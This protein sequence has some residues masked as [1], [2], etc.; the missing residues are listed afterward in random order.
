MKRIAVSTLLML[1]STSFVFAQNSDSKGKFSGYMFGDYYYNMTRDASI[2]TLKNVANGGAQDLNGIGFRRI[3]FAYSYDISSTFSTLFRLESD[4]T[5]ASNTAGGKLGVMVKDASLTWKNIFSGSDFIFGLQPT[6]AFDISESFWGHRFLEKTIMDLRG[7]VASRD[8]ALA[9][10]GKLD[11]AGTFRY[12]LMFGDGSGNAPEIDNYKRYYLNLQYL[13]AK[14]FTVTLY[15][16]LKA[17]PSI[18]NPASTSSPPATISNNEITYAFFAGYN[19]K[20]LFQLGAEG[21]LHTVENGLVSG[22]NAQNLNAIGLTVYGSYYFTDELS[23]TARFDYYN[24]NTNSSYTGD[25][26]NL[27]ILSVNY[28]PAENVT[29][30]PNVLVETYEKLPNGTT[31]KPSVTPRL[32]FFYKFF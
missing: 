15:T 16:D 28:E 26:R 4:Q 6:P 1:L 10:K 23:A 13:P 3:Y 31:F 27:Y 5:T 9:L 25:S 18:N 24:P 8:L 19:R 20:K 32:T 17:K 11:N 22:G 2:S 7:I 21:F 29:V 12:W 14:D 30:S